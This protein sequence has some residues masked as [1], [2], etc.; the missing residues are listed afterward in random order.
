MML[1]TA[2]HPDTE[3]LFEIGLDGD[4]CDVMRR[5]N[6]RARVAP[7]HTSTILRSLLHHPGELQVLLDALSDFG[8][9]PHEVHAPAAGIRPE[10]QSRGDPADSVTARPLYCEVRIG[11]RLGVAALHHLGWSHRV[12]Q[13]TVVT[14]RAT[15]ASLQEALAQ[16][17]TVTDVDYVVTLRALHAE[18]STQSSPKTRVLARPR[19]NTF[20]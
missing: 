15:Q 6:L 2:D 10:Q 11:G 16:M 13:T 7:A 20:G 19:R 3:R 14:V 4:V 18:S 12:V 5:S 8:I 9:T 17:S 1:D